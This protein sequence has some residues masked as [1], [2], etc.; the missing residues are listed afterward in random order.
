M[1]QPEFDDIWARIVRH[2]G[3]TFSTLSGLPL[4]YKVEGNAIRPSRT[5]YLL[6]R[7]NFERAHAEMPVAGPAALG[8]A[9]RGQGYVWAILSDPRI[10]G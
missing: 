5:D 3:A 9:V 4:T 8:T 10:S 7:S 1:A 6:H 2:E